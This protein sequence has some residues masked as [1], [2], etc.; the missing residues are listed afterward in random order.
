MLDRQVKE[1]KIHSNGSVAKSQS[2]QVWIVV[3]KDFQQVSSVF[4]VIR[5]KNA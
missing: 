3:G 2:D 5:L 1:P 4:P